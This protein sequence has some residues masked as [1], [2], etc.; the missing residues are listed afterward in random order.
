MTE[1]EKGL[2]PD[3][4]LVCKLDKEGK[5]TFVNEPLSRITGFTAAELK[6]KPHE[7][8]HHPELPLTVRKRVWDLINQNRH[9]YFVSKN[10]TKNHEFF[11]TVADI[12]PMLH[13]GWNTAVFIRKKFLPFEVR[14]EFEKL[15][16][17]L[18]NIETRGGGEKT[19]RKYLDG[20]LEDRNVDNL[21]DYIIRLFGDEKKLKHYLTSEI[22][23][24]ELFTVDPSELTLEE[25]L[26]KVNK[27]RKRFF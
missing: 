22:S 11:W 14:K 26:K 13:K 2:S 15:Y 3:V 27:K 24:E 10:I 17:I 16:D 23:D 21:S 6:G 8:L 1:V 4:T 18:Y 9:S 25:I 19:A 12:N 5:I 20:W 7:I